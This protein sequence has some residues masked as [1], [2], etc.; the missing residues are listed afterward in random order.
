MRRLVLGYP[1]LA[2]VQDSL[3]LGPALECVCEEPNMAE[4]NLIERL[5]GLEKQLRR[6]KIT[7]IAGGLGI[8]A[9]AGG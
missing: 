2:G 1:T 5:E 3:I 9:L 7:V 8:A 6:W 4:E